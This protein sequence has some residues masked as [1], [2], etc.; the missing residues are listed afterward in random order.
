MDKTA[1]MYTTENISALNQQAYR[2]SYDSIRVEAYI[3]NAVDLKD[4]MSSP[5]RRCCKDS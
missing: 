5:A 2:A 4:N 3:H 1:N